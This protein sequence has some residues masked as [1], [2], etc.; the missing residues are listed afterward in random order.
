MKK[1]HT[2]LTTLATAIPELATEP[3]KITLFLKKGKVIATGVP[4]L[5]FEY[6]YPVYLTIKDWMKD[7]N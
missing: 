4:R 5:S 7:P 1:Y 3:T 6:R 2:L